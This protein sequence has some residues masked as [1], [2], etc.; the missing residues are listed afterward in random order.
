MRWLLV[1]VDLPPA[2]Q[3]GVA[4]WVDD[5]ATA[6]ALGG[7]AVTVLARQGPDTASWDASRP[8][9][10]VRVWG[11]SWGRW[12]AL[13]LRRAAAPLLPQTDAVLC[14]TWPCASGV[15]ADAIRRGL[16]VRVGAHGSEI[17]RLETAPPALRGLFAQVAWCPVS[18]FLA[19]QLLRLGA[20]AGQVRVAPMPL[21]V[22]PSPRPWDARQGLV[23]VARLTPLKGVERAIRLARRLQEPLVVVGDGPAREA[24]AREARGGD[25]VFRGMLPRPQ[26][27]EAL[28]GARAAVLLPRPEPSGRGAE[29]LGL[30]LLEAAARGVPAIGCATGG[31]PEAVGPGLVLED[32]DQPRLDAVL[33]LL[34]D[35]QAGAR[36]MEWV[37]RAHG[38]AAFRAALE[39]P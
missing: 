26:A 30:V 12:Q 5:A 28:A 1:T 38:P 25:V 39:A 13:W 18:H 33:A 3:G 16:S 17:T 32:A 7:H 31:V 23:C 36:A 11:R 24:L 37:Q 29:G 8:Y 21:P 35:R 27:L 15:A 20:P 14:A 34:S 22:H 9:R 10:V 4:S 2:V 19:G 6:L